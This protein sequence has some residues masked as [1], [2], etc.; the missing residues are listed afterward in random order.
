MYLA[1]YK[2]TGYGKKLQSMSSSTC[3]I[4]TL[5]TLP[6]SP[7]AKEDNAITA[8][9]AMNFSPM[10]TIVIRVPQAIILGRDAMKRPNDDMSSKHKESN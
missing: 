5:R 2:V 10:A 4:A 6:L 7:I 8:G 3:T 9:P 1:F